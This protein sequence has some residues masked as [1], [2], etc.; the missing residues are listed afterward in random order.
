MQ[1]IS[2]IHYLCVQIGN[3]GMRSL[4]ILF[5]FFLSVSNLFAKTQNDYILLIN[6]YNNHYLWANTIEESFRAAL[7]EQDIPLEV[8]SEYLNAHRLPHPSNWLESIRI[9]LKNYA[10]RPPKLIV[11]QGDEAWMAY[12]KDYRGQFGDVK[13]LLAG[14]KDFGFDLDKYEDRAN[15]QPQDFQPTDSIRKPYNATGVTE[16]L[17]VDKTIDMMMQL[18][19]QTREIA[20]IS[21]NRFYGIY[22]N[23][24]AQKYIQEKYPD[25]TCTSLDG[26]FLSTDSLYRMIPRLSPRS[27]ILLISWIQDAGNNMYTYETVFE[28]INSL[29]SNPIFV[30][31]N[32]GESN[33][34]FI[35]GYYAINRNFGSQLADMAAGLLNGEKADSIPLVSNT[36]EVGFHLNETLADEQELNTS[37]LS[38]GPVYYYN[39]L[40]DFT[41]KHG[42]LIF[43]GGIIMAGSIL[44]LIIIYTSL[45]FTTY[46][47]ELDLSKYQIDASLNNQQHLSDA[48]KIFLQEKTEKDS[49]NKILLRMLDELKADRAYIF[50]FDQEKQTS[51]NTYEVLSV[52]A[53]PQIDTLQNLPNS[54]VPW[55]YSKMQD[56][57]LLITED[58]PNSHDTILEEERKLLLDQGIKSMFV[59]PLYVSHKLWGY[60]GV[61]YVTEKRKCST[62]D[63]MYLKTLAQVL[64]IGIEHFRSEVRNHLSLQRV[65]ELEMLFSY[66]SEQANAGFAQ[67]NPLI[68]K[69]FAT[70]QWFINLGE[71]TRDINQV[72]NTLRHMH[73][74][75][76][77]ELNQFISLACKGEASKFIKNIRIRHDDGW[78][79]YKYH[80][81]LKNYSPL[82][83]SIELV[84]LSI[85]ID[86]LKKTEANLLIAKAKAEESD[87]L[88]SAFIA[89]MSH[90]IRTP[91]NAI[92]GF[93]NL[94]AT[95]PDLDE[96]DR[97]DYA[98]IIA[99]NTELLLQLINDILDMSKIEAG[100]LEFGQDIVELDKFMEEIESA[101]A[102]RTKEGVELKYIR[103]PENAVTLNIDR[104]RLHQVISNF[105]NNAQKFTQ[106]GCIHFG[107]EIRE[108][109]LY[110]YVKD[111]GIGIPSG[112]LDEIFHRFVKLN[113]FEQGNGLGLSI[114]ATIVEKFGGEIGVT[115]EPGEGSVFWFTIP[116]PQTHS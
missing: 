84:F 15:L 4:T 57:Q 33:N 60:V 20:I 16:H 87:K 86:N 54:S 69:G 93:S 77:Q 109:N 79:W 6:S 21:D 82:T 101:Y 14:V 3:H 110:V 11:L 102:L 94:L 100:V 47:K 68:H 13:I 25:I 85:N 116:Y 29:T 80:A 48:L 113:S 7:E 114:C 52:N 55:L 88:K 83:N 32:W 39:H 43:V 91:L 92:V 49:V 62:Q 103:V 22:S 17:Y 28:K 19:P 44:L 9:I 67:W 12:R 78:H 23:M 24:L 1:T 59:A 95:E 98:R 26:Q 34:S 5:V 56:D 37:A 108:N 104:K 18:Y 45:R 70:D 76:R 35:G 51:S 46:R 58:L 71:T 81:T 50:E 8:C 96:A 31:G 112:K 10:P 115:S 53:S 97:E 90:E 99:T 36:W 2:Q 75:D 89:N 30:L 61:D 111:T 38:G 105:L 41:E 27:A 72:I 63:M 64:C 106:E 107:Y 40:P 73:P 74:D 65:A 42:T 66:A